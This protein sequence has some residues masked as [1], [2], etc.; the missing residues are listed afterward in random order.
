MKTLS[1]LTPTYNRAGHLPKLFAS[2]CS[3]KNKDFQW[4]VID[5]GSTDETGELVA[6][7]A[8]AADFPIVYKRKKNGG[9]HTALNYGYQFIYTPLTFIVDSDDCLTPDAVEKVLAVYETYREEPDLCG[10]SFLRGKPDGSFLSDGPVPC[11]GMKETF[12]QC[13]INRGIGGDMAEVW[14]THCLKEYPFPVFAGEKFLGEDIVWIR[15]AEKYQMRFFNDVIYL[16]DYL[17]EGLTRN[18]RAHNLASPKGCTE[19]ARV[20]LSGDIHG[21][22]RLKAMMQY[23]VYGRFAGFTPGQLYGQVRGKWLFLLTWLPGLGVYHWWKETYRKENAHGADFDF[24]G[25]ACL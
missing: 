16:S 18:R 14:Y 23:Q 9:K 12:V 25:A 13:R 17:E 3:Q 5:D 19:R 4:V 20:F 22:P 6:G 10:F 11:D 1:I 21:L 24:G 2:L 15:M 8:Q 7:F